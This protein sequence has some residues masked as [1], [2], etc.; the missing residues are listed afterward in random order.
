[1]A[2]GTAMKEGKIAKVAEARNKE[3]GRG[4]L[5]SKDQW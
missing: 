1:V 5:E 2:C 3:E 4:N